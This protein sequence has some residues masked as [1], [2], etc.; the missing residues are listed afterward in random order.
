MLMSSSS[1]VRWGG[2]AAMLGCALFV[3]PALLI[4]SML[5]GRIG[6]ECALRPMRETGLAGGLLMLAL[7]LVVVGAVG[8]VIRVRNTERFGGLAKAGIV[9]A[10][11][12]AALP[13]IGDLVQRVL[14]EG[15][16]ALMPFF[17]IPGV[18]SP[19]S[20]SCFWD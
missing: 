19:W 18:L 2:L 16:Y 14:F 7:L 5:R 3:V 15:S 13:V 9:V 6:D 20:A 17:V 12:G 10:A 4:A 8:L 11:V 1:L